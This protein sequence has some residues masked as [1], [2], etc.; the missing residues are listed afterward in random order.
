MGSSQKY[1]IDKESGRLFLDRDLFTATAYPGDYGFI[2]QTL[3]DDGDAVDVLIISDR[4]HLPGSVMPCR[5]IALMKMEDEKGGDDKV[6]CVPY[7]KVNPNFGYIH[8][9]DSIDK[10]LKERIRHFFEHYKDLE[11]GKWVKVKDWQGKAEAEKF[12]L[13]SKKNYDKKHK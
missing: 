2:P 5:P 3:C 13:D 6:V 11:P 9:V 1:E 4:P 10:G 12:I 8:D 7:E